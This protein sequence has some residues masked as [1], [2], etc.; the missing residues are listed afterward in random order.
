MKL[1]PHKTTAAGNAFLTL[2]EAIAGA[3]KHPRKP[4][5]HSIEF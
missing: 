1:G 2:R 5:F 3:S 4:L